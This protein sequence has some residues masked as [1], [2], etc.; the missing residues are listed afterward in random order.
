MQLP[1]LTSKTSEKAATI[2]KQTRNKYSSLPFNCRS[3]QRE[4][5]I[6]SL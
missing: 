3:N 6:I 4:G 2:T 1:R 5:E